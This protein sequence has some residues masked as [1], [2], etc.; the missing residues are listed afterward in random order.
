MGCDGQ[1]RRIGASGP[2][3]DCEATRQPKI[4][5]GDPGAVAPSGA[6]PP[7]GENFNLRKEAKKTRLINCAELKLVLKKGSVL[8]GGGINLEG[9]AAESRKKEEIEKR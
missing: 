9:Q 5:H 4:K 8:G 2:K 7:S 6:V 1:R 3:E